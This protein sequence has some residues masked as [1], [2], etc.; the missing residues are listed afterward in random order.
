[1][2]CFSSLPGAVAQIRGSS[3]TPGLCGTVK[4]YP[5]QQGVLVVAHIH[6]LPQQNPA[7]FFAIH[8]H[9]GLSCTGAGF[10][11]TGGHFNPTDQPHPNHAGDLPPLLSCGGNAYS[12]VLTNRFR[13]GDIL[14]RTVVIHSGPDDFRTQP[15]GNSGNKIGC[16]VIRAC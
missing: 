6:G 15:A 7:G 9:Q 16:G 2:F 8:I 5:H 14:G 3:D 12:A 4:F 10:A 1:M 11:D 13:L